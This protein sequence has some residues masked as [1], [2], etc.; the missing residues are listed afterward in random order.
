MHAKL[1]KRIGIPFLLSAPL[2]AQIPKG[3]QTPPGSQRPGSGQLYVNTS[4]RQYIPKNGK[5]VVPLFDMHH[6]SGYVSQ[7]TCFA[8]ELS[9]EQHQFSIRIVLQEI[10]VEGPPSIL[11]EWHCSGLMNKTDY[12]KCME[13]AVTATQMQ[14]CGAP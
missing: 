3:I 11:V 6:P 7:L 1:M 9:K 10:T 8:K 2:L 12:E 5:L 13:K 4:G 14:S